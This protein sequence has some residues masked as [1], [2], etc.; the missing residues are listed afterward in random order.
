MTLTGN[1]H[2]VHRPRG[3]AG[4]TYPLDPR[5]QQRGLY[6]LPENEC[7]PQREGGGL[8]NP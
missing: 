1:L 6:V 4:R 3:R 5:L 8:R 7:R 2:L